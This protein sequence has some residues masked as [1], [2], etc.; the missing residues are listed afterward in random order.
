MLDKISLENIFFI[1]IETVPQFPSYADM[2]E[3]FRKLWDI[4]ASR[5]K[6]PET[7]E[8]PDELYPRAGIYSEF[9][10]IMCISLGFFRNENGKYT[11]RVKSVYGE[12]EK[13]VLQEYNE[14]MK[15]FNPTVHFLCAHNGKEFDFPYIARRMIING[16]KLPGYL[17]I[18][19][20]KPW[21]S[22]YLVDTMQLWRFGDIKNYTSLELLCTVLG[23]PTPKNDIAGSDVWHVYWIDHALTRIVE[24]C[25]KD[26]VAIARLF[27][28][29]KNM[30]YVA[31]EN[32]ISLT[33][34]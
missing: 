3:N 11:F 5:I 2:P 29:F 15:S 6:S 13:K 16:M 8:T 7:G 33:D 20:K 31:D 12:D 9:G 18:A 23:I 4:K 26:V 27:M 17:D 24:Y 19:G 22:D 1:D 34:K 32:I 30:E 10:K 28:K 25:E 14:I 21:E